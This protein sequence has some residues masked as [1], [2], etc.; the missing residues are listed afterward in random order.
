MFHIDIV[1]D[2]FKGKSVVQQHR[3]INEILAED[4][5]KWHGLQLKTQAE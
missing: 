3:L 1:S 2:R 4:I 5:K